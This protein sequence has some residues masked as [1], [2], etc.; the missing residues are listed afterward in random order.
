M[1]SALVSGAKNGTHG[2]DLRPKKWISEM[3]HLAQSIVRAFKTELLM[4]HF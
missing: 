2:M 1:R 3:Q 4:I